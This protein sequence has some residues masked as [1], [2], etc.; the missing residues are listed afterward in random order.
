MIY[1]SYYSTPDD[2]RIASPAANAKV[3]SISRAIESNGERILIFSSTTRA[4]VVGRIK[5]RDVEISLKTKC[6]QIGFY[7]SN[8]RWSRILQNLLG[9]LKV[10]GRL[11]FCTKRGENVLFYHAIE[12]AKPI[13]IAKRIKRF[14]LILEVEEIYQ[15]ALDLSEKEKKMEWSLIKAA[16]A[17]IF[18]T[19]SLND[20]VNKENKPSAIIYGTYE[21][22]PQLCVPED[23]GITHVV[24]AGTL[25][26]AKGGAKCAVDV[27]RYLSKGYHMHILGFGTQEQIDGLIKDIADAEQATLCKISYDGCLEG[28]EYLRFLQKCHIGLS[29]HVASGS[30]SDTSFPSKILSYMANGLKVVS[31]KIKVVEQSKVGKYVAFPETN[32]SVGLA[33]AIVSLEGYVGSFDGRECV[34]ALS[35][36]FENEIRTVL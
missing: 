35:E 30:F 24:Y 18:P 21:V 14:R 25:D 6:H 17:F 12:R 19:E 20:L 31:T 7:S 22:A 2:V 33:K 9:N 32:D 10:F 36:S 13:L 23:D 3:L 26:P 16:D 27:A 15:N 8:N 34:R 4:S 1:V 11:L 28:E 5:G 29:S